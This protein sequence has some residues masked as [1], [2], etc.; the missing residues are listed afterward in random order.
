MSD[1]TTDTGNVERVAR[2]VA[3]LFFSQAFTWVL[4]AVLAVALPRAL[5]PAAVGRLFFAQSL[6]EAASVITAFGTT[7]LVTKAVA[8][9]RVS[10][11]TIVGE[12]VVTRVAL[13]TVAWPLIVGFLVLAGYEGQVIEVAAVIGLATSFK[14]VTGPAKAALRGLEQMRL[15]SLIDI[16]NKTVLVVAVLTM[17]AVD[18][19]VVLVAVAWV[20]SGAV[21]M[22]ASVIGA[23]R[24]SPARFW[25]PVSAIGPTMSAGLVY[26]LVEGSRT[27]YQQ[28]DTVVISLLVDDATVGWYGSADQIF[29]TMFFV[30]TVVLAA[31]F[32][33]LARLPGRPE[34]EVDR[35]LGD[36]LT[37][38]LVVAAPIGLGLVAV[39]PQLSDLLFGPEFG[40]TG[41]ALSVFGIAL[42]PTYL[43]TFLG[44]A[45]VAIDRQAIWPPLMIGAAVATIGL[46]VLLVP[47]AVE[48]F[49]NGALGGAM[50][51]VITETAI[52][53]VALLVFRPSLLN[54]HLAGVVGRVGAAGG[55][56]LAAVWAVRD[57]MLLVPVVVGALVY[58][59]LIFALGVLST[60]Q[61]RLLAT[62]FRGLVQRRQGPR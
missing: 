58:T 26:V 20:C 15:I 23:R 18:G 60:E 31:V 45:A 11:S 40:P 56:M 30:P 29:Q 34:R 13:L 41:T 21:S 57:E 9:S 32:P 33:L 7:M 37:L 50:S 39:G 16:G 53:A 62:A 38:S 1:A 35:V 54:R 49:D 25:A 51:Y 42:I 61:R 28:V 48:R 14:A 4:A 8:R 22:V 17:I 3:W 24:V 10:A 52:L 44:T 6:W 46:D 5:G 59:A 19:G 36:G 43:S 47:W 55:L 2:N 12:S 27:I